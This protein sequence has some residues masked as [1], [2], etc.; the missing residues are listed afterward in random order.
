MSVPFDLMFCI[1]VIKTNRNSKIAANNNKHII[2]NE[3]VYIR[4]LS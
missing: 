1:T 3:I 4:Q 2:T